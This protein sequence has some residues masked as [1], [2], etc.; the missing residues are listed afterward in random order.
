[1]SKYAFVS[2]IKD[3]VV[4]SDPW[5]KEDVWCQYR[6]K[7][8]DTNWYMKLET[9]EHSGEYDVLEFQMVLGRPT[10]VNS[11][12][13]S[14]TEEGYSLSFPE[15][16]SLEDKELGIDSA[17]IY[18]GNMKNFNEFGESIAFKTGGD[19]E[20]G[21]LFVYTV[22]GEDAPAGFILLGVFGKDFMDEKE[23]FS[24]LTACFDGKEISKEEF[25]ERVSE[26]ALANR[27]LLA[28]ELKHAQT[29]TDN[30]VPGKTR[31]TAK[32]SQHE[33]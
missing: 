15:H 14:E 26:K 30:R 1:M 27:M 18:L 28:R 32:D 31:D 33:H 3:G 4:F 25:A 5:Y 8:Q 21:D 11:V 7:F 6:K 12:G 2:E 10:M 24:H 13:V 23:L 29:F 20:F 22:K 9:H 16:Y 19:G 17:R